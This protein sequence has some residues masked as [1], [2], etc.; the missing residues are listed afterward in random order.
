[1]QLSSTSSEGHSPVG[2]D[3]IVTTLFRINCQGF[4]TASA[5]GKHCTAGSLK[6]VELATGGSFVWDTASTYATLLL[7]AQTRDNS[8]FTVPTRPPPGVT[9]DGKRVTSS[10]KTSNAPPQVSREKTDAWLVGYSTSK[11]M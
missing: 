1:M 2:P 3:G 8:I 6:G 7:G 4:I 5:S 10:L 11:S 9:I